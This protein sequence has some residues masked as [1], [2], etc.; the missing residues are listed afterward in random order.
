[1]HFVL[2]VVVVVVVVVFSYIFPKQHH[3][4]QNSLFVP[5]WDGTKKIPCSEL[6]GIFRKF[7]GGF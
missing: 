2:S 3:F 7:I 1:M 5:L 6:Q 4:K